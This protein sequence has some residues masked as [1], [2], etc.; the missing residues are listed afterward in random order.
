MHR[1]GDSIIID[2]KSCEMLGYDL[3]TL[4]VTYRL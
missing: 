4:T 1:W 2:L 3:E